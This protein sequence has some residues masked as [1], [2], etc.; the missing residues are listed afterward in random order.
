MALV[1]GELTIDQPLCAAAEASGMLSD[2][3]GCGT[4]GGA[5]CWLAN[6]G[7]PSEL[8]P[9]ALPGFLPA[10]GSSLQ[11]GG[12]SSPE[13][14]SGIPANPAFSPASGSG[15]LSSSE[16]GGSGNPGR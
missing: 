5:G 8:A 13:G 4:L 6:P 1:L 14:R 12:A 7:F 3:A 15:E 11:L 9:L 16:R 10:S 2:A